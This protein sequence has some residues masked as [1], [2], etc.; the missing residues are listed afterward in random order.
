MGLWASYG[1]LGLLPSND[2][3]GVSITKVMTQ[4][5]CILLVHHLEHVAPSSPGQEERGQ[6]ELTALKYL[7]ARTSHMP[8][9]PTI[10][11]LENLGE[12]MDIW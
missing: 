1:S 9:A 5:T 11:R 10:R 3:S 4:A 6:G 12:H 2:D 8:L 7:L